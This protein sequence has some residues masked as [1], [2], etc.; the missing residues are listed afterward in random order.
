MWVVKGGGFCRG[1]RVTC[2]VQGLWFSSGWL[3]RC[4]RTNF[5]L[6][7]A[8]VGWCDAQ[9]VSLELKALLFCGR[10]VFDKEHIAFGRRLLTYHATVS[11]ATVDAHDEEDD[12]Q[13]HVS[14]RKHPECRS[15]PPNPLL[16]NTL[17]NVSHALTLKM[18]ATI[19]EKERR[20]A[21]AD[22]C[23]LTMRP[24]PP[25]IWLPSTSRFLGTSA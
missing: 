7:L 8:N 4:T 17:S 1:R 23:A 19:I 15:Q 11:D 22:V 14:T 20:A 9:T 13:F 24:L 6:K 25:P 2:S 16:R 5:I 12:D 3:D 10:R 18:M 21:G